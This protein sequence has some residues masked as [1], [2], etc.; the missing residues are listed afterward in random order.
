MHKLQNK[1][2]KVYYKFELINLL[3]QET[4]AQQEGLHQMSGK[5]DE[6]NSI[7]KSTQKKINNFTVSP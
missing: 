5:L 3:L 7:L 4:Q 2:T 6:L 1:H